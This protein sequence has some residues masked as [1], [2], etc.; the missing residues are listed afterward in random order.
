[1]PMYEYRCR[2]CGSLFEK[3]RRLGEADAEVKCPHCR[4]SVVD[5]QLSTFATSGCGGTG[6]QGFS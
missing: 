4:S 1:M 6:R 3:L 5:R 2:K